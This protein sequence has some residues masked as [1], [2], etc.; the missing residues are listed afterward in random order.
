MTAIEFTAIVAKVQTLADGGI[1]LTL[2]LPEQAIMQAAQLMVCK[3]VGAVLDVKA[4]ADNGESDAISRTKTKRRKT[5]GS[6]GV[7]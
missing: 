1:R 5:D 6:S 7:Q 3:R 4:E 2:D